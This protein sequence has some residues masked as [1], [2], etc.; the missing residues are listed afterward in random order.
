MLVP[1]SSGERVGNANFPTLP[2]TYCTRYS[3]GRVQE[4]SV[5][6][7]APVVLMQRRF[8]KGSFKFS[9]FFLTRFQVLA[10]QNKA[11]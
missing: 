8:K 11:K 6:T 7:N 1:A 10:I 5:L 2:Q 3:V 9:V 4:S